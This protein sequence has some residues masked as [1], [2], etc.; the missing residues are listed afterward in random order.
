M[1][2]S[3]AAPMSEIQI[4][5]AQDEWHVAICENGET[6]RRSFLVRE[7]A[8]SFAVGHLARWGLG[9]ISELEETRP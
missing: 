6:I 5:Y 1:S 3:H 4:S 8:Y 7:H 9:G 2:P